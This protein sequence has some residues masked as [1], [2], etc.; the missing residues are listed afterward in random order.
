[1]A[2]RGEVVHRTFRGPMDQSWVL[3]IVGRHHDLKSVLPQFADP[4]VQVV[5]AFA[6]GPLMRLRWPP[7]DLRLLQDRLSSC[8]VSV[9]V[10]W[11]SAAMFAKARVCT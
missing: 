8:G 5:Q 10:T 2:S 11:Y 6:N 7:E 4:V 3:E 1:M 9:A